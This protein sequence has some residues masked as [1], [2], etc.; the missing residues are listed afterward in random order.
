MLF[1]SNNWG[2]LELRGEHKTLEEIFV[3]L[4]AGDEPRDASPEA[5]VAEA[6]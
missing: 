2:L 3:E 6:A 1:R 4:T 5:T